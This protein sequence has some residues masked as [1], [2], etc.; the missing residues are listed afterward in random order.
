M[1][2]CPKKFCDTVRG[3]YPHGS[4]I[5]VSQDYK[6]KIKREVKI[7]SDYIKGRSFNL[8]VTLYRGMIIFV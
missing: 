4:D 3:K 2:K 5:A 7:L 8:P 1:K 6:V